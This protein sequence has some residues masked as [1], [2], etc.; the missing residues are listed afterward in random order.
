MPPAPAHPYF[1]PG[2]PY[3]AF[4]YSP[5]TVSEASAQDSEDEPTSRIQDKYPARIIR[6]QKIALAELNKPAGSHMSSSDLSAAATRS[7]RSHTP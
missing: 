6:V 4:T 5:Q 3:E 7:P 1:H 2:V